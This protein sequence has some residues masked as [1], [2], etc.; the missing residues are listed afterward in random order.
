MSRRRKAILNL[1]LD[2]KNYTVADLEAFFQ[3]EG[4]RRDEQGCQ[5]VA[6]D[7]TVL[8]RREQEWIRKVENA[9]VN[10]TFRDTFRLFLQDAREIL[11]RNMQPPPSPPQ[12]RLEGEI[13]RQKDVAQ[14]KKPIVS[15]PDMPFV[16]AQNSDYFGGTMNPLEKH[17]VSRVI[18]IHSLFRENARKTL[19]TDSPLL[20]NYI[21]SPNEVDTAYNSSSSSDFLFRFP[22]PLKNVASIELMSIELPTFAWYDVSA[23]QGSNSFTVAIMNLS[24]FSDE[25]FVIEISDGNYNATQMETAINNSLLQKF[26]QQHIIVCTIDPESLKTTFT[27]TVLDPA[28]TLYSPLFTFGI[29]FATNSNRYLYENLGWKLGFRKDMYRGGGG[30]NIPIVSESIFTAASDTY[31]FLDIDDF[32][33][34]NQTDAIMAYNA[35]GAF[36]GNTLL[37]RISLQELALQGVSKIYKKR[38]YFGAIR[39]EKMRIRLLN[40]FGRVIDM[41]SS[42]YSFALEIKQIYS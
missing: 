16:F 14:Y 28:N 5:A 24:G 21:A 32:N 13:V 22:E 19:C 4:G 25:Q 17:L 34:N 6:Y 36:I 38:E 39:L 9:G 2:I 12:S 31:I 1:D 23:K 7:E 42:D 8:R 41:Q 3:L 37:A 15:K 30:G 11:I 18:C 26:A 20:Q 33:R 29:Q 35:D 10:A 27:T 40:Q